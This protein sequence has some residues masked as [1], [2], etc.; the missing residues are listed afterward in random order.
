MG[1]IFLRI[2]GGILSVIVVVGLLV[3]FTLLLFNEWRK[4]EYREDLT[5][6]SV[7]LISEGLER[8][9]PE[10]QPYWLEYIG[11]YLG[12]E[13]KV[14][15][16]GELNASFFER[17]KLSEGRPVI[18][19]SQDSNT[20]L[21]HRPDVAGEQCIELDF[22]NLVSPE[23][24]RLTTGLIYDELSQVSV[25]DRA[26]VLHHIAQNFS[27]PVRLISQDQ[28]ESFLDRSNLNALNQQET[29]TQI[30]KGN[31]SDEGE[32]W[33]Y[34]QMPDT[35]ELL[36]IGPFQ[37]FDEF[38]RSLAILAAVIGL[39]LITFFSFLIIRPLQ[40][41]LQ[42]LEKAARSVSE[43][44]LHSKVNLKKNSPII[45]LGT[46]FNGMTE[47]ISRLISS[48]Q[49][50]I[51]A[52]SHELRTPIA[53][54]RFGLEFLIDEND[55]E[56][57]E[58]KAD[59]LDQDIEQL[60]TLVDEI[61]AYMRLEH[62]KQTLEFETIDLFELLH[63]IKSEL[64]PIAAAKEHEILVVEPEGEQLP[65]MTEC[66]PHYFKRAILNLMSNAIKYG[67]NISHVSYHYNRALDSCEIWVED[68]GPGIPVSDRSKIFEPFSRLD[69]SRTLQPNG[70]YGLGLSIVQRIAKW[71][72]GQ[73]Y[74]DMSPTLRGARFV[75][76]WP[77]YQ[78]S[79]NTV[80]R[81]T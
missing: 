23:I 71:H 38:P 66:N 76:R 46:V 7:W 47:H 51:R 11:G 64:D 29:I 78:S 58:Q 49:E 26:L 31:Q 80:T 19:T 22:P 63:Q 79:H 45:Q 24:A 36:E 57:R 48:Q 81:S 56:K 35:N 55:L 42:A 53:R 20:I 33:F 70:G 9:I 12:T 25:D 18:R 39:V 6:G 44:K 21:Y 27:Y 59:E 32:I 41:S 40:S 50:M 13:V 77:Q 15:D 14:T 61:I 52:I 73:V 75:F 10:F 65:I 28:G 60:N 30:G 5:S 68:T 3:L 1:R 67:R 17:T 34:R 8:Y 4:Q 37:L 54:L 16:C 62:G 69:S 43:G 74:V 72:H 2:Y